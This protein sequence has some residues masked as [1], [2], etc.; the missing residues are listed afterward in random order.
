MLKAEWGPAKQI[1]AQVVLVGAGTLALHQST[2]EHKSAQPEATAAI[3]EDNAQRLG[4]TLLTKPLKHRH[5]QH[6]A[7]RSQKR[8][9]LT[10]SPGAPS[11][12]TRAIGESLAAQRGWTGGE[13]SCLRILWDRESGWQVTAANP[14]GAYGIPQALPGSK[15]ES[16]GSD[17]ETN[18]VTQISWGLSYIGERYGTPCVALNHQESQGYY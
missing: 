11:G 1:T 5:Q 18:P 13:W 6:A 7:S 14:S 8:Q 4:Q 15:M 3:S 17:W 9:P 12:S 10:D 2:V 16:A